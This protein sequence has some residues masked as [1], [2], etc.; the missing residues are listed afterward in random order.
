MIRFP[1]WAFL[2]T[3]QIEADFP[4]IPQVNVL[5]LDVRD[6]ADGAMQ[7]DILLSGMVKSPV[8]LTIPALGFEVLIPNCSPGEPNIMVARAQTSQ[9]SVEPNVDTTAS[10]KGLVKNLPDELTKSCPGEEGSP[11]DYLVSSY[12]QGNETTIFVRGS[13][14]PT[15]QAPAWIVDLLRSVTIPLPFTGHSLDNLVQNFTMTNTHFSLPD[16]FAE[17]NTPAAQPSVSAL[18]KVVIG[19]PKNMNFQVEVPEVRASTNV[20]YEGEELGT[21]NIEDWEKANS[22]LVHD[23]QHESTLLLVDFDIKDAPLNVTDSSLLSRVVQ[24]ML[25]GTEPIILHVDAIVDAKVSTGLGLF[26][27]RGIPADGNVP[28]KSMF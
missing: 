7:A 21:L 9:I 27:I 19:L 25:F 23:D 14:A 22:T 4:T 17:P 8:A 10:V 28:V 26:A 20:Y 6:A 12:I 16:P 2:I 5:Q 3:F 1:I 15:P 13:D 24:A 11:L 18:V